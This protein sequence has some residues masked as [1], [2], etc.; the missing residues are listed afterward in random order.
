MSDEPN[1]NL[2]PAT[3]VVP[4]VVAEVVPEVVPEAAPK[5][6]RKAAI[7]AGTE[8][9]GQLTEFTPGVSFYIRG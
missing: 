6:T 2:D 1:L 9:L 3:V 4:E 7:P 8:D 5:R